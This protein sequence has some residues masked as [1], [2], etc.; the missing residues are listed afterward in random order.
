MILDTKSNSTSDSSKMI[1]LTRDK[2][3]LLARVG[4]QKRKVL[5]YQK[6]AEFYFTIATETLVTLQ[7]ALEVLDSREQE[8]GQ[9]DV[10]LRD[11][12]SSLSHSVRSLLKYWPSDTE[13]QERLFSLLGHSGL[14][15]TVKTTPDGYL[16]L[17][18]DLVIGNVAR[19]IA[20]TKEQS[21]K[22]SSD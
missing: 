12:T 14:A 1:R 18:S 8:N 15:K 16:S 19:T 17:S 11:L 22:A 10:L 4:H 5:A 21:L 7:A 2:F 9:P 20:L 3:A 6:E 13:S